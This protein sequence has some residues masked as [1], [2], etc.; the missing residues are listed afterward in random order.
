ML[1]SPLMRSVAFGQFVDVVS[2]YELMVCPPVVETLW[3]NTG[4]QP[5]ECPFAALS[6]FMI[7]GPSSV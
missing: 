1:S 6:A 2:V 4:A 5:A 7:A 3:M